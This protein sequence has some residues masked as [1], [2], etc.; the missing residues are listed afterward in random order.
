[1][2]CIIQ[3]RAIKSDGTMTELVK[4]EPLLHRLLYD[5]PAIRKARSFM[6]E[7][8]EVQ[9]TGI[10]LDKRYYSIIVVKDTGDKYA[11]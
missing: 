1:M 6:A 11:F 8:P 5:I 4:L 3:T 2:K 9:M 7:N 10:V